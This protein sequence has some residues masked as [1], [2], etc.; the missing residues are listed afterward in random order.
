MKNL[1][2]KVKCHKPKGFRAA[3]LIIVLNATMPLYSH[4]VYSVWVMCCLTQEW[5]A[6]EGDVN[7]GC[8]PRSGFSLLAVITEVSGHASLWLHAVHHSTHCTHTHTHTEAPQMQVTVLHSSVSECIIFSNTHHVEKYVLQ[9]ISSSQPDTE[10]LL[11]DQTKNT[12]WGRFTKANKATIRGKKRK[13]DGWIDRKKK[14]QT[15]SAKKTVTNR[16]RWKDWARGNCS[17][18]GEKVLC[19]R[20][21]SCLRKNFDPTFSFKSVYILSTPSDTSSALL[22]FTSLPTVPFSPTSQPASTAVLSCWILKPPPSENV[23]KSSIRAN[24]HSHE[25]L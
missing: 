20:S 22:S 15:R 23:S 16:L 3:A 13:A 11:C 21:Q 9:W 5:M 19:Q 7:S 2:I 6:K 4:A 18:G 8:W 24:T 25:N 14:R 17:R 10:R 1:K 12:G